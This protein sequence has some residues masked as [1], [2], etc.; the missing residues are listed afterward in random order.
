MRTPGQALQ[1]EEVPPV[2]VEQ[3]GSH[4]MQT[5]PAEVLS[6]YVPAGHVSTQVVPADRCLPATHS[7]HSPGPLHEM[8]LA[9]SQS[10]QPVAE[11]P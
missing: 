7:K 11:V 4:G 6:A 2:H 1:S 5:L 10:T 3:L 8:Q 9:S